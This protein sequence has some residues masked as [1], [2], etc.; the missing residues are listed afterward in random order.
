MTQ[1]QQQ[2]GRG[3]RNVESYNSV[4]VC[5]WMQMAWYLSFGASQIAVLLC[6]SGTLEEHNENNIFPLR[7]TSD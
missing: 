5:K 7:Y 1:E 2:N 3:S 4:N 6:S